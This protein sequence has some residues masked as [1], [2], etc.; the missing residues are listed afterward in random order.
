VP[1]NRRRASPPEAGKPRRRNPCQNNGF[2]N[3]NENEN[4]GDSPKT[5]SFA[6]AKLIN[7][8]QLTT[9]N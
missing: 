9:S 2:E 5:V 4:E 3:E 6:S 8:E 7:N 1:P